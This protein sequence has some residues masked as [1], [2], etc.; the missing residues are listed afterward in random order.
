MSG[1]QLKIL[2]QNV[3]NPGKKVQLNSLNTKDVPAASKET[4]KQKS[5]VIVTTT[6]TVSGTI[7]A[8]RP[9]Q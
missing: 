7:S 4:Q 2:E 6:I 3:A 1:G 8:Y 5:K 9:K